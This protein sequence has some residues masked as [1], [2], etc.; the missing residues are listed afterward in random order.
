MTL[1]EFAGITIKVIREDGMADYLPTL[2]YPDTQKIRAIQGIPDD[3]DHRE[4]I[5]NVVRRSG[6]EKRE[7]FFGVRSAPG[8]IT[9][10]HF[11]PGQVT[12]F[13]DIV[14]TSDGYSTVAVDTCEW[15][16]VS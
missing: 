12:E 2:A 7:F 16:K 14:E 5:Q 4:A 11:R 8:R 10:G 3:V 15:W 13:M 6:D 1:E 9:T